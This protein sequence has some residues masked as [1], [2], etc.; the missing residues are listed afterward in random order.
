MKTR[1]DEFMSDKCENTDG[2]NFPRGTPGIYA[3][4]EVGKDEREGGKEIYSNACHNNW[5]EA[6]RI[7]DTHSDG[8]TGSDVLDCIIESRELG[9]LAD[10]YSGFN[11][12]TNE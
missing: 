9:Q 1:F 10:F 3:Y 5:N 12:A 6:R 4:I 7:F 8:S 11:W 2:G